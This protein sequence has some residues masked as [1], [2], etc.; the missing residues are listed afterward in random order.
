M[1]NIDNLD[2]LGLWLHIE[3]VPWGRTKVHIHSW[4]LWG[5][6]SQRQAGIPWESDG[7]TRQVGDWFWLD[8]VTNVTSVKFRYTVIEYCPQMLKDDK[9]YVQC[10]WTLSLPHQIFIFFQFQTFYGS[11][12]ARITPIDRWATLRKRTF[13]KFCPPL[14][15][16]PEVEC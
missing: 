3:S 7:V 4:T 11:L 5:H 6:C 10:T 8:D 12:V 14:A 2:N 15:H 1:G 9:M 13:A 16:S